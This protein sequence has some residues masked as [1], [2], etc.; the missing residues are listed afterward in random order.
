M[1]AP[2]PS[3]WA[4]TDRTAVHEPAAYLTTVVSRLALDQLRS[5][6]ATREIYVGP[7]LP[8]PAL[9]DG[10]GDVGRVEAN[11]QPAAVLRVGDLRQVLAVDVRDGRIRA[12][13]GI[14]N[15]DKL[16]YALGQLA[17]SA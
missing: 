1:T 16:R 8:E 4:R 14:A 10:G 7:W 17:R 11:G 6:R 3:R 9:T 15:P 12:V 13:Y 2:P 5:A